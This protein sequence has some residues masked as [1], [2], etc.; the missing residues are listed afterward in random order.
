[1]ILELLLYVHVAHVGML[2]CMSILYIE[3]YAICCMSV[4]EF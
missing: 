2:N 3:Y 4:C 1:M